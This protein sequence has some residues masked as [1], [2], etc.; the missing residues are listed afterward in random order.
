MIT[1]TTFFSRY[2]YEP[3]SSISTNIPFGCVFPSRVTDLV[4]GTDVTHRK[5]P[6]EFSVDS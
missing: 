2:S 5:G 6:G 1:L 3:L 4:E